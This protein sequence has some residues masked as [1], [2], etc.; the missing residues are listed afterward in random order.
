M[1]Y[2]KYLAVVFFVCSYFFLLQPL[3]KPVH[4]ALAGFNSDCLEVKDGRAVGDGAVL[5]HTAELLFPT[6]EQRAAKG[7]QPPLPGKKT[8]VFVCIATTTGNKCTSG[9]PDIDVQI[10][11]KRS[12]YDDLVNNK[13]YTTKNIGGVN[14]GK[15][16]TTTTTDADPQFSNPP[17]Y[18][19][20]EYIP[21]VQ[22]S[23][24]W[25]QE[26]VPVP[27]AGPGA[28]SAGAQQQATFD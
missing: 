3:T 2:F 14:N 5:G 7:S 15:N 4:A 12:D 16:P 22:H 8:W 18:W 1:K 25:L 28:G 27:D 11:G 13:D 19:F 6:A 26:A 10:F 17:I 24:L 9:N 20:D 21:A 23:W